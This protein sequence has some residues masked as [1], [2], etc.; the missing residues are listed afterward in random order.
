MPNWCST[1]YI[2]SGDRT[3]LNDLYS[4]MKRLQ[5]M[6]VPL[7]ENGF[8][9]SWLGCLVADMGMSPK[10]VR[11]RGEWHCLEMGS[12]LLSFET[13]TAWA[14]CGD[15]EGLIHM[16]YSDLIISFY[17]EEPGMCIFESYDP[18]GHFH[19]DFRLDI[20][21]EGIYCGTS[22]QIVEKLSEFFGRS[23]NSLD[24]ASG[25]VTAYRAELYDDD[26]PCINL[27]AIESVIP[28]YMRM[29]VVPNQKQE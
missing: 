11:C 17:S 23:F 29:N 3:Q 19:F 24:E 16:M 22:G 10:T 1:H 12:G 6:P 20:E 9:S 28:C 4:R 21:S 2:I 18:E 14:R 27:D 13:T 5:E 25:A 15:V 26:R 7:L 8:G